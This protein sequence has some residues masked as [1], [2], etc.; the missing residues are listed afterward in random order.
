M[1][2]NKFKYYT[3]IA[4]TNKTY[5]QNEICERINNKKAEGFMRSSYQVYEDYEDHVDSFVNR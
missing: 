1:L 5:A 2:I 3:M 4:M